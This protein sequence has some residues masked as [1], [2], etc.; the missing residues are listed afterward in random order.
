MTKE[1][2][3]AKELMIIDM[4]VSFSAIGRVFRKGS[5]EKIRKKLYEHIEDFFSVSSEE[6]YCKRHMEFCEWITENIMTAKRRGN[7][8]KVPKKASWGQA[9]KLIDVAMKA[10]IYYCKLPSPSASSRIA[11]WLNAG[12]D[13]AILKDLKKKYDLPFLRGIS[14]LAD[15]NK[16]TYDE[17]QKIIRSDI[18][19]EIIP[20]QYDDMMWRKLNQRD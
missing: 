5:I 11:P 18:R 20:V 3:K 8:I 14:T 6:E 16:E 2:E 17:L 10:C 4:A 9:A 1:A 12:I 7:E 19:E 13:T 15:I